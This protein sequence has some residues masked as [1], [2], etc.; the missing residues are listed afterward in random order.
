[1]TGFPKIIHQ[2]Y[3]LWDS[4]I[5]P[6]IQKRID[7]WKRLHPS[8]KYILWDKKKCRDLIKTHYD[9]FLPIYDKYPY[10]IQRADA[11]RYFILFRYG[12]VYS[13]IDLEP[14]KSI[15]PLLEKYK[16]KMC[17]LYRSPNSDMLTNDFIISKPKNIFWKKVIHY[18]ITNSN[19]NY[20]TKH[21]TVMN[22]TG[23]L[24]LD[25]VY[26]TF[27]FKTKHVFIID[28]KYVNNCDIS[29]VKPARNK[30]A[31]LTRYDGNSWHSID[32]SVINFFYKYFKFVLLMVT[33]IICAIYF[34]NKNK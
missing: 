9:W 1:M 11:V 5:P 25:Y 23:P 15:T 19:L 34:V 29:T 16:R 10:V 13:D 6:E 18:M 14:A 21:L 26:E 30:G 4:K 12:G 24:M 7:T 28:A 32:S 31:F 3:G 2:C 27:L 20:M 22:T 17:I 8:Y 33:I